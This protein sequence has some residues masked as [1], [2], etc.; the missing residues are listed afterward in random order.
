MPYRKISCTLTEHSAAIRLPD[1]S[2]GCSIDEDTAAEL[3][4]C[5][6]ELQL[7]DEL[8]VVTV[9]GSGD[10]FAVGRLRPPAEIASAPMPERLRW[11]EEM[12]VAGALAALPMPTVAVLN[13]DAIAHGLELALAADLRIAADTASLGVGNP[14]EC[15]FPYDGATQRLPRLVGPG[16]AR[17]MLFTGRKLTAQE[18][19]RVGLVNRVAPATELDDVVIR[20]TAEI[21]A[22]APIASRYVKEA[23]ANSMDLIL[24][25]GL[26]LE[27][28]LSVILQSTEDR[29]EGLRSFS[30][31]RTP[32]FGGR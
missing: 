31:K 7:Q 28:D 4:D 20:L 12:A 17:D 25:Q 11:Q 2:N 3:R 5:C 1:P 26:R 22:A 14:A 23:V 15:G 8:R 10:V 24:N 13:G 16:L 27:A 29:A 32:R 21:A 30:E 19:L 18:A 9:A 6:R